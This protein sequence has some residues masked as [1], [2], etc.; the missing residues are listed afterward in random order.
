M[1]NCLTA[2]QKGQEL[3][4]ALKN[5]AALIAFEEAFKKEPS[6][7]KAAFGIGLMLQRLGQHSEAIA[8]FAQVIRMQPR[9]AEAYYSRALS[10]QDLGRHTEAL[11][12][13]D[14]ALEMRADY[15]DAAYARGISLKKL[16]RLEEASDAYSAVLS[17]AGRYPPA[18]HGRATIRYAMADYAAAIEDFSTC[19]AD[20]LDSYDVRLLRGLAFHC[21]GRH[22]EAIEDLSRAISFRPEVGSTYIRRWQVYKELGDEANATQDFQVGTKL[23][24]KKSEQGGGANESQPIRSEPNATPSADGTYR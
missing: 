11:N 3:A 13:L 7:Y 16:E 4:A 8:A 9:I 17:L 19:I 6:D 21:V 18:S 22:L 20:G 1:T 5:E 10:L 24:D 15:V 14:A 2:Y 23:L 12:D